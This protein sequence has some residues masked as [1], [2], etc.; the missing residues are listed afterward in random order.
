[1]FLFFAEFSSNSSHSN[2]SSSSSSSSN[3]R[4][5][6]SSRTTV[7]V[8]CTIIREINCVL[9]IV[10]IGPGPACT[11]SSVSNQCFVTV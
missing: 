11:N 2:N 3:N 1:M 9:L 8:N 10:D 6:S 7:V 5:C 4:S